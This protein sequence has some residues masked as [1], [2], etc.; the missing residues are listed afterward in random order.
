MV[1]AFFLHVFLMTSDSSLGPPALL[2]DGVGLAALSARILRCWF[3]VQACTDNEIEVGFCDHTGLDVP[4]E[5]AATSLVLI[6]KHKGLGVD[7]IGGF[8]HPPDKLEVLVLFPLCVLPLALVRLAQTLDCLPP[9]P[10]RESISVALEVDVTNR[11]NECPEQLSPDLVRFIHIPAALIDVNRLESGPEDSEQDR[12]PAMIVVLA[13][14][15]EN[16]PQNLIRSG[17]SGL[18]AAHERDHFSPLAELPQEGLPSVE[19]GEQF[20]VLIGLD[21]SFE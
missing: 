8:A 4:P 6:A 7:F 17:I 9:D 15:R 16:R 3:A 10:W 13:V 1:L 2:P 11:L 21:L 14:G 5:T 20:P 19:V 18:T 12:L